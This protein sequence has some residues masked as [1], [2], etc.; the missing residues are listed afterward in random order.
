MAAF[1]LVVLAACGGG[2]D[3]DDA[4]ARL[5]DLTLAALDAGD[6]PIELTEL[7]GPAVVNLWA[8]W[9]APCRA[10]LPD[11]QQVATARPDVR[12]VGIDVQETGDARAFLDDL[13]ITFEQYVDERG[14]LA[15]E[16]GAA[17]M[18]ITLVIDHDGSIAAQHLGPMTAAELE[19]ELSEADG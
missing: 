18:P 10:E 14:L 15:E 1:L 12:F 11:F 9:C 5:P 8:T 19:D 3:D 17:V 2:D 6:P 13:G 4:G 16:L 7:A